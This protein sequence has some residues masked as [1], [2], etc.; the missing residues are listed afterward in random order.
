MPGSSSSSLTPIAERKNEVTVSPFSGVRT[1]FTNIL[2]HYILIEVCRLKKG[3]ASH[4]IIKAMMKQ[5]N[6]VTYLSVFLLSQIYSHNSN[7]RHNGGLSPKKHL[8]DLEVDTL[9][10]SCTS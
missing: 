3:K 4:A 8:S 9:K 2:I 1:M 7:I 5:F 10:D 6:D